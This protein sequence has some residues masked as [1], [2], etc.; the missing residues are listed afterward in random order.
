MPAR[1]YGDH[2]ES[3]YN[4]CLSLA[5]TGCDVRVLTTNGDGI[6]R[7]LKVETGRPIAM[8]AGFDVRYERRWARRS[9]APA[10]LFRL[11]PEV[12][13]ADVVHLTGVYSY[14]TIPTLLTTV[15]LRKPLVWS[16]RG[17]FQR[18]AGSRRLTAKRLWELA[19][20]PLAGRRTLLHLT[21]EQEQIES[22][23]RFPRLATAVI[24]NG[25]RVPKEVSHTPGE[26]ALRFGFVG[27][28]DPKKGL[29]NL[30]DACAIVNHGGLAF[31]L[32]IAGR[33]AERYT[34]ALQARIERLGLGPRVQMAGEVHNRA[35][36]AFFESIDLLIV[37]SHTE[38]FAL[39]VAEALASAVPVIASRGT[40]WAALDQHRCGLWVENDPATL[41]EAIRRL[42]DAPLAAMGSRGREWMTADFSWSAIARAMCNIYSSLACGRRTLVSGTISASSGTGHA[43]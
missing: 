4:L 35:K 36:R 9:I 21:S 33:G 1:S 27:R 43:I 32:T 40:P 18:W 6:G 3:V 8:A 42:G 16:P 20:L 25:V 39:A 37:P 2:A 10:M 31:T 30:I 23:R 15:M 5:R 22:H 29:E 17:G 7:R 26:G 28:L 13:W 12:R 19:C 38:N 14:P 34:R 41:A 24:P 11:L